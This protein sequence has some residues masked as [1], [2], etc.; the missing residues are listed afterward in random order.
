VEFALP[1]VVDARGDAVDLDRGKKF[2]RKRRRVSWS[3]RARTRT[4]ASATARTRSM[5]SSTPSERRLW[6][7]KST[8]DGYSGTTG[9]PLVA[10]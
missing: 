5:G 10:R 1:Q 3:D 4:P 9:G 8:R 2:E 6:V 7:W